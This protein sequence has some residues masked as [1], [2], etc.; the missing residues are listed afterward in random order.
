MEG[1][2]NDFR[3]QWRSS[4]GE[5]MSDT[6]TTVIQVVPVDAVTMNAGYETD[7]DR[8]KSHYRFAGCSVPMYV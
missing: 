6:P 8:G 2:A 3:L 7:S 1:S 5:S 4:D